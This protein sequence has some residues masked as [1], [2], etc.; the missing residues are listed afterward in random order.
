MYNMKSDSYKI[1]LCLSLFLG[2]LS[3]GWID[4]MA[5]K[6]REGN[7]LYNNGKYDE[8]LDKYVDV[9]INF[10]NSFSKKGTCLPY[11]DFNI[12][13]VQYKRGKYDEAAQLFWKGIKTEDTEIRAKSSFN[14]GNTMYRQGKMKDALEYYKKAVDFIDEA[15]SR[16]EEL[17]TLKSDAKYNYEYI[18]KKMKEEEQKQ[19]SQNQKEHQQEKYKDKKDE[20]SDENKSEDKD[21]EKS[22]EN[23]QQGKPENTQEKSENKKDGNQSQSKKDK[24][25]Q[26]SEQQQPQPQGLKQMSKE[27]A[28]RL[29]EALNQSEKEARA[30]I[31]DTQHLQH[32]SVEK[33]W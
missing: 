12:A 33:D 10:P 25:N 1:S 13:D 17:D 9:Q 18:E 30:T 11:L 4:P 6:V 2:L 8:A 31:K 24:Q 14:V 7:L 22:Q 21:K 32:K 16:S 23:K 26:P 27:E 5:D 15:Q 3:I 28:E 20:K 19:Q 29:L